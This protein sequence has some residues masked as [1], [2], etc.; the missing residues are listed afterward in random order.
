LNRVAT[1]AQAVEL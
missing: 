1:S